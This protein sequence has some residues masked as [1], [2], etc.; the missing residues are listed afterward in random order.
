M[1]E[2]AVFDIAGTTVD[3]GG[4]VYRV[5][6]DTVRALGADPSDSQIER[7]MGAGK[8]EA[9]A[10][11]LAQSHIAP[12]DATVDAGS[13]TFANGWPPPTANSRRDRSAVSPN[14]WLLCVPQ[15]SRSCSPPASTAVS[16]TA[17]S[18]PSD[19]DMAFS[20]PSFV[21]T[22]FRPVALPRT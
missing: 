21:S 14:C 1:I 3:E 20:T 17:F 4:T 10:A 19:G 18:T 15:V 12:D 16:P 22:M 9:I 11:L 6:A 2:L 13:P 5:L 7:W 8:R